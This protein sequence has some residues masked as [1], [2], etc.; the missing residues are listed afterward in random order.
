MLPPPPR[1]SLSVGARLALFYAAIFFAVGI[2]LPF[3]PLWLASRGMSATEIGLLLAASL[4]ARV[5]ANP[6]VGHIADSTGHRKRLMVILT[7]ASIGLFVLFAVTNGFWPLLVLCVLFGGAFA[8]IMPL[9]ENLAML[10]TYAQRLDYGRIRLWGSLTFI[11]AAVAGGRLLVD[12]PPSTILWAILA[13]L[14]ATLVA[15]LFL[16]EAPA[17]T[18]D[19]RPFRGLLSNPSFWLFL[20]ATGLIHA[21]HS[22]Y[23]G[24]ATLHWHSVGL[25]S[26]LIGWL[27]AE[28]VLAEVVLFA[29]SGWVVA[30]LGPT[31]LLILGAAGGVVRWTALGLSTAVPVLAAEQVLHALTF[32]A[33]H[34]GAMHFIARAAPAHISARAQALYSSISMGASLGIAMLASGGLYD[35]L[36]GQAFLVSA[37]L[38]FGGLLGTLLLSR[39]WDGKQLVL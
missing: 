1:L 39:R 13:G 12:Y 28:A 23:Y 3:W 11:L 19:A 15:C 30:R 38:A 32:G 27:W 4:W 17:R 36:G 10:V 5:F 20:A 35:K 26:D 22:V 2:H 31:W 25:E 9:G 37:A 7:A 8:A 34:L 21:S 24:F 18:T 6:I 16:P 29:F 14:G 33:T